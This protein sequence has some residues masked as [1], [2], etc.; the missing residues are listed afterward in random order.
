MVG[1]ELEGHD[2]QERLDDLGCL[3]DR[4]EHVRQLGKRLITIQTGPEGK[5][6]PQCV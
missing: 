3:G 2:G 1:Q 4:Q 5:P 6:V